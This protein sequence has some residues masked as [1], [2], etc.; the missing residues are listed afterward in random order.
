MLLL[1]G[2]YSINFFLDFD[3]LLLFVSSTA[4]VVYFP[5][6]NCPFLTGIRHLPAVSWDRISVHTCFVLVLSLLPHRVPQAEAVSFFCNEKLLFMRRE[7]SQRWY[8][9]SGVTEI[10]MAL[11]S[12]ESNFDILI[13]QNSA[14]QKSSVLCFTWPDELVLKGCAHKL[15]VS[16]RC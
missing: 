10:T 13:L 7:V 14:A 11:P 16:L 8:L 3:F 1:T 15:A 2:L 5:I 12:W 6:Y 9:A 4:K